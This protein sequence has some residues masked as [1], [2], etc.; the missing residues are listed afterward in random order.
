MNRPRTPEEERMSEP[1]DR[2]YQSNEDLPMLTGIMWKAGL[3]LCFVLA[4][5]ALIIGIVAYVS[6]EIL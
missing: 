3:V 4:V 5:A 1:S 2:E 6:F